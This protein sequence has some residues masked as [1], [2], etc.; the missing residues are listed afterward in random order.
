MYE[1]KTFFTGPGE[2]PTRARDILC[3]N[4]PV[5]Q[6]CFEYAVIY[7]EAGV[8]GGTTQKERRK[9]YSFLRDVLINQAKTLGLYENRLSIDDVIRADRQIQLRIQRELQRDSQT[10]SVELTQEPPEELLEAESYPIFHV[11]S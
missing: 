7:D 4:C 6:D 8:W 10:E 1:E 5:M 11:A 2:N 3:S 9:M